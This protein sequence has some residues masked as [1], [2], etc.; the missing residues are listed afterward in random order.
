MFFH[1]FIYYVD[2]SLATNFSSCSDDLR[3][4]S[5]DPWEELKIMD[6]FTPQIIPAFI[7]RFW[8]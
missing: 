2:E 1:F 4:F 7:D 5:V 6:G 3:Y 8:L